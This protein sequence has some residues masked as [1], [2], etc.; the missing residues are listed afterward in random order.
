MTGVTLDFKH[1]L[2]QIEVV[3]K[4]SKTDKYQVSVLGVKLCRIN[5][6]GTMTFQT[7]AADYPTWG[8]QTT[9]ENFMKRGTEPI[10]LTAT[11]QSI[12]FNGDDIN[13]FLMVPQQLRAWTGVDTDATGAYLA[14]LCRIKSYNETTSEWV[15]RYP[16]A[17]DKYGFTAIP[18]STNWLPG[19]K[20]T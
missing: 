12:M 13:T 5:K 9:P 15:Q 1:A 4:N 11:A 19:H 14:V 10:E 18:I 8:S 16:D 20:Y 7:A 17:T 6:T 3:A 2:A